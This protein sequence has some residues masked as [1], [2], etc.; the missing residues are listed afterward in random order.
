[1]RFINWCV[2]VHVCFLSPIQPYKKLLKD[3]AF[4]SFIDAGSVDDVDVFGLDMFEY[5]R[6]RESR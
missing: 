6:N 3:I 1:M 2:E 5:F 4:T